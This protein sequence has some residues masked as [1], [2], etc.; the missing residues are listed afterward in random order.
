MQAFSNSVDLEKGNS[1]IYNIED[2]SAEVTVLQ[3]YDS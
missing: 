1:C 2:S 3:Q